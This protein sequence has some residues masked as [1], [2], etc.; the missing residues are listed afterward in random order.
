MS[1]TSAILNALVAKLGSDPEL[2]ALVPDNVHEDMG[3][4]YA[5]RFVVVSHIITTDQSVMHQGRV[6]EDGLYLVEARV[7]NGS[8]GD[9]R[10]AAARIDALLEDKALDVPGYRVTALF[11]E[12]FLRGTEIDEV[13]PTIIWKRRG[14][15]YR[16]TAYR[17]HVASAVAADNRYDSTAD[18]F[19]LLWIA[20]WFD[21]P[22]KV[23]D[24]TAITVTVIASN[25]AHA[26]VVLPFNAGV[27]DYDVTDPAAPGRAYLGFRLGFDMRGLE[28]LTFTLSDASP[29]GNWSKILNRETA[30]PVADT[31]G[32]VVLVIPILPVIT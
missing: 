29:R 5:K 8:G 25:P 23:P 14:G 9:V 21:G 16:V 17:E 4:P 24:P 13:D 31:L 12:E 22:I 26:N 10:A 18:V 32:D 7:L 20:I 6:I 2:L 27:S 19:G 11:R 3:P 28:G 15:R 30:A 1:D